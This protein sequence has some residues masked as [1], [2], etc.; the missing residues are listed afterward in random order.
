MLIIKTW[1]IFL[2]KDSIFKQMDHSVRS[3]SLRLSWT[4]NK[5]AVSN[6]LAGTERIFNCV[7]P[8]KLRKIY[9]TNVSSFKNNRK[10]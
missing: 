10:S 1:K 8:D 6:A 4:S 7:E 3:F 5:L 9:Y 2:L